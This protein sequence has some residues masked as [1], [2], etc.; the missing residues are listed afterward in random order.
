MMDCYNRI[1]I[2]FFYPKAIFKFINIVMFV[3]VYLQ[4]SYLGTT[5]QLYL[6]GTVWAEKNGLF[7]RGGLVEDRPLVRAAEEVHEAQRWQRCE[8]MGFKWELNGI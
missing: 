4:P 1:F 8:I 7:Q 2:L 6:R 5:H 3:I